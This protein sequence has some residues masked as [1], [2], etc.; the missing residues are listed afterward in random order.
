MDPLDDH[1][2]QEALKEAERALASGETPVG[3]IFTDRDG[4]VLS[5]G[6]NLTSETRNVSR[7][8]CITSL[9]SCYS[10]QNPGNGS[11]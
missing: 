8:S 10:P 6:H 5:R 11:R 3:C 9:T 2:M 7:R 4:R 1:L